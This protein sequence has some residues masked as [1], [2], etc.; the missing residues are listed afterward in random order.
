MIDLALKDSMEKVKET[1]DK[2][3]SDLDSTR[4]TVSELRPKPFRNMIDR[5]MTDIRPLKRLRKQFANAMPQGE[6]VG[7]DST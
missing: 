6:S 4:K 7:S 5:R 2:L 1:R 3:R